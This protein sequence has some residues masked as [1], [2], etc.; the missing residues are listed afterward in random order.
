[1]WKILIYRGIDRMEWEQVEY[2]TIAPE[3][4][5]LWIIGE[6]HVTICPLM[7]ND[8]INLRWEDDFKK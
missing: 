4:I 1:M 3:C 5:K 8:K 6:E 7:R 2:M